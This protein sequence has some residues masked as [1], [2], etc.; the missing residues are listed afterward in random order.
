MTVPVDPKPLSMLAE[1]EAEPPTTVDEVDK[2]VLTVGATF[3]TW[4][5]SEPHVLS[6]ALL[7]PSPLYVACQLNV[8][9][10]FRMMFTGPAD[11]DTKATVLLMIDGPVQVDPE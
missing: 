3:C 5:D 2:L 7:F 9:V 4:R 10:E 11:V 1:S 6:A 8:P